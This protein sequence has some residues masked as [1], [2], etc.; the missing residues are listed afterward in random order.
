MKLPANLTNQL[1]KSVLKWFTAVYI[2]TAKLS[3]EVT[4]SVLASIMPNVLSYWVLSKPLVKS[5]YAL[6]NCSKTLSCH[7]WSKLNMDCPHCSS[8]STLERKA[9]TKQGY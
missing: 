5:N 8:S 9:L 6:D 3:S 4:A 7:G 1:R 2:I